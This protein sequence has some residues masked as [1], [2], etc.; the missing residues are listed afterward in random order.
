MLDMA[1]PVGLM[2]AIAFTAMAHG[3]VEPLSVTAFGLIVIL[4]FIL[5][6]IKGL[7]ERG[8]TIRIPSTAYPLAALFLL[9]CI[10]SLAFNDKSGG[11]IAISLDVEATRMT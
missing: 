4:L 3:A 1:L 10:Q 8:I 5:W 9:G 2:I 6:M 11:L 7:V